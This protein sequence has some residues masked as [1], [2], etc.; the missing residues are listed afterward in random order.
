MHRAR[1]P[2]SARIARTIVLVLALAVL[3]LDCKPTAGRID[4]QVRTVC[5]G[6]TN[7]ADGN[8]VVRAF[9]CSTEGDRIEEPVGF[10][11]RWAFTDPEVLLVFAD[12]VE[13]FGRRVGF[14]LFSVVVVVVVAVIII[15]PEL[16]VFDA[17]IPFIKV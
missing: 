16:V 6:D 15:A 10:E 5:I 4:R 8:W 7:N 3:R 17:S 9:G 12:D 11:S 1:A 13:S 14:R 2:Q